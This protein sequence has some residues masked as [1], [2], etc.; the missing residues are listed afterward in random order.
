M[1]KNNGTLFREI[2]ERIIGKILSIIGS[3][4][5]GSVTLM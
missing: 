2:V 4:L 3:S 1:K 5:F